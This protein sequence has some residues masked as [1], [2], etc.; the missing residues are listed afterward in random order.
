M[1]HSL[2][3]ERV[4][5]PGR[6]FEVAVVV[7]AR[8]VNEHVDVDVGASVGQLQQAHV[9]VLDAEKGKPHLMDRLRGKA[10][11]EMERTHWNSDGRDVTRKRPVISK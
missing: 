4:E 8:N 5:E 1:L 11:G 3:R 9:A 2:V 10:Y 7:L 6:R